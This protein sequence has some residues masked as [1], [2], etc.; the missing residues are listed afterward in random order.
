[1]G[2]P[3]NI[4]ETIAISSEA[5]DV[6]FDVWNSELPFSLINN[7]RINLVNTIYG[8]SDGMRDLPHIII[9]RSVQ[10]FVTP[11][12]IYIDIRQNSEMNSPEIPTN[13]DDLFMILSIKVFLFYVYAYFYGIE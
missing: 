10:L 7:C 2:E 4:P 8:K 9:A 11:G 13:T 6:F 5:D 3:D 12:K 1:M